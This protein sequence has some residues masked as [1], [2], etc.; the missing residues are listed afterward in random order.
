MKTKNF[1][2]RLLKVTLNVNSSKSFYRGLDDA[3]T[4]PQSGH[5]EADCELLCPLYLGNF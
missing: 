5:L 3:A 4:G 2:K 1:K